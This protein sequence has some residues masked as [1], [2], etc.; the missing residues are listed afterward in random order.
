MKTPKKTYIAPW[1]TLSPK[2]LVPK[3]VT[4][5]LPF[6]FSAGNKTY[7]YRA[8]NAIYH[9]IRALRL[10]EK[11]AVL[12]PNY[13]SG[14]E[15]MAI[16]AAGAS[17]RFYSIDR[18][19]Q[20]DPDEL[21]C[22]SRDGARVLYVI[23]Y[24]GWP[25]P[26]REMAELCRQNGLVLV[27]DCALSML[28]TVDAKPLGSFGDFAVYC[29]YKTLPV[30]NGGLLVQNKSVLTE[31]SRF[32]PEP[33]GRFSAARRTCELM[34]QW[35][36]SR[37][38]RIGG[39]LMALK[40]RTGSLLR[41]VDMENV[42][43]GNIGFEPERANVGI[44]PYSLRLLHRFDYSRLSRQRIDNFL[45]LRRLLLG[46]APLVK[47]DLGHGIVPLFFPILVS[48]KRAAAEM[49]WDAGIGVVEFWNE[50]DPLADTGNS[51][52]ARLLRRHLLEIPIHQDVTPEQVQ[53]VAQ[54][55]LRLSRQS[56]INSTDS[57]GVTYEQVRD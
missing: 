4:D 32:T 44:A 53:Y 34:L 16:R 14:N 39:S 17:I 45:Q 25:Q 3:A 20:P 35:L 54:Q 26:I 7:F 8:S 9:L 21:R 48:D 30:P 29:L 6:P 24:A 10:K 11:D 36:R 56:S 15:V 13:H 49:L 43:I 27:E 38:D 42:P 22:L 50:G 51:S 5:N 28:S 52:D 23:H 2:Y 18:Q 37:S 55:V 1:P 12:V 19:F 33:C 41:S 47:E 57:Y 46:K 31:L 40:R